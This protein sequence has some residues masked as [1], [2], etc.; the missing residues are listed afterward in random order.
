VRTIARGLGH[1]KN[2]SSENVGR[3]KAKCGCSDCP[4]R[5][6]PAVPAPARIAGGA[7]ARQS[8]RRS[9][10]TRALPPST[11]L[12]SSI[13]NSR[14]LVLP[15][16]GVVRLRR[17]AP[18]LRSLEWLHEAAN[19]LGT[20][21]HQGTGCQRLLLRLSCLP[22]HR[23][24]LAG[25][26]SPRTLPISSCRSFG[27]GADPAETDDKN[28]VRIVVALSR[29]R[30]SGRRCPRGPRLTIASSTAPRHRTWTC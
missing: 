15:L 14:K 19:R 21:L 29:Q 27:R 23:V 20:W 13:V 18:C 10:T 30:C 24:A 1:S 16:D 9:V 22:G 7:H 28:Y 17:E 8:G 4:D 12:A 26:G 11:S 3:V 25:S 5:T 6:P 2:A